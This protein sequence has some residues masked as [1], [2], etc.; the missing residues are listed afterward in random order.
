[1]L[2]CCVYKNSKNLSASDSQLKR[3]MLSTCIVY[4]KLFKILEMY[5]FTKFHNNP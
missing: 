2:G 5:S 3:H 1:M 4:T